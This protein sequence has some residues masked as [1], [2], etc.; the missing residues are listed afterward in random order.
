MIRVD[1]PEQLSHVKQVGIVMNGN[2][3]K[4]FSLQYRHQLTKAEIIKN[5]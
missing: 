2:P 3:D 1:E 5:C 4:A